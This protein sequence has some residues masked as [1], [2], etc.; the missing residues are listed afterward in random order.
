MCLN[1]NMSFEEPKFE[2]VPPKEEVGTEPSHSNDIPER[3]QYKHVFR[4]GTVNFYDTREE[5]TNA[6]AEENENKD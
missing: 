5:L 1:E 4:D 3:G 6:I 2:N